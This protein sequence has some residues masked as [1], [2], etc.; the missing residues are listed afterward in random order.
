MEESSAPTRVGEPTV[1]G[2]IA[3]V[4]HRMQ[5]IRDRLDP[6]DGVAYFNRV[7]LRLS[8]LV[9]QS[10]AEGFFKDSAFVERLAVIFA[11]LYFQNVDAAG[12]AQKP[13]RS[14]RPLFDARFNRV[15]WPIQ[16]ALAG[17][18]AHINHDL[19]LA[20]TATCQEFGKGPD[21]PPLHED[22]QR[23]NELVAKVE[24]EVRQSFE[25]KLFH[26]AT[27]D[28]EA[29]KHIVGSWSI[30]AARDL[31]WDNTELLWALRTTPLLYDKSVDALARTVGAMGRMLVTAVVPPPPG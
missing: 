13:D 27:K 17:M 14:W 21:T 31:A 26:L 23:V 10:L 30:I 19:A 7:Y 11:G 20:V 18:N 1:P 5:D 29:L 2:T 12:V 16:F 24:S 15:V 28:A 4:I 22:Y 25:T 3:R 6:H 9:V 8:E